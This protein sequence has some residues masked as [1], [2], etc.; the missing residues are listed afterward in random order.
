MYTAKIRIRTDH[1]DRDGRNA[2]FLDVRLGTGADMRRKLPLDLTWPLDLFDRAAG[3]CLPRQREDPEAHDTNLLLGQKL[4]AANEVFTRARLRNIP[5]TMAQFLRDFD[6]PMSKT[7]FLLY[8]RQKLEERRK[9]RQIVSSTYQVAERALLRLQE[10]CGGK[11]LSTLSD[12]DQQAH[13]ARICRNE[14]HPND[15]VGALLPFH[16]LDRAFAHRFDNWLKNEHENGINTRWARH[17]D[18]TTYLHLAELDDITFIN[19]YL[20]FKKTSTEGSWK[21]ISS[22]SVKLLYQHYQ[23]CGPHS[24]DRHE[25]QRYLFSCAANLRIS[26]LLHLKH[27]HLVGD[28]LIYVQHK[29]RRFGRTHRLPLTDVGMQLLREAMQENPG[30]YIFSRT[31]GQAG[32]RLLKKIAQ[33]LGITERLHYHSGRETYGTEFMANGGSLHVL[34]KLMGHAKITTTMKYV[35]VSERQKREQVGI[36]DKMFA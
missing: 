9:T 27:E 4:S 29:N 28:E 25:L 36:V 34:Q 13:H 12:A 8:F 2:L 21:P 20:H 30:P 6:N 10:F 35:H 5:L 32:N 7:D 17:K 24:A 11:H 18:V 19:P 14:A 16:Q 31:S 26:D 3:R 1:T 23:R 22:E 33:R 15:L